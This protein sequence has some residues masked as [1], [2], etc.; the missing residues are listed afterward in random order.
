M[1]IYCY[2]PCPRKQCPPMG[3][4]AHIRRRSARRCSLLPPNS[5]RWLGKRKE[6]YRETFPPSENRSPAIVKGLMSFSRVEARQQRLW[7]SAQPQSRSTATQTRSYVN[8]DVL[9]ARSRQSVQ[10][11][12]LLGPKSGTKSSQRWRLTSSLDLPMALRP[13]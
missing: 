6:N 1:A 3:K 13:V 4:R 8:A 2:V 12:L 11:A 10:V 5:R 9:R 7:S